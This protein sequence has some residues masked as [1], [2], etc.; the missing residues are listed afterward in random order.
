MIRMFLIIW[1]TEYCNYMNITTWHWATYIIGFVALLGV[2][3]LGW[4]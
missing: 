3:L 1:D 2:A 4:E